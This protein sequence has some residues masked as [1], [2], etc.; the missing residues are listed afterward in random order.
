MIDYMDVMGE[1]DSGAIHRTVLV[2]LLSVSIS[3]PMYLT[4]TPI[5]HFLNDTSHPALHSFT[6]KMSEYDAKLGMI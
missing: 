5:P 1:L 6:T 4:S 3:L 2:H